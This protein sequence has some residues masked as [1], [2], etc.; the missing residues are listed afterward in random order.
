MRRI[1]KLF[2]IF[3][4]S[5][6]LVLSV[7]ACGRNGEDPVNGEN[8][9]NGENDVPDN[10]E[11][12]ALSG[13]YEIDITNLGMPLVIYLKIDDDGDFMLQTSRAF[14]DPRD[15]GTIR[16]VDEADQD[17]TYLM[18]YDETDN[19]ELRTATFYVVD[20]NLRFQTRM[21]YGGSNIMY[22]AEDPHDP[23]IM[24]YLW[25][26]SFRHE[27]HFGVYGGSHIV[28]AMGQEV[29]YIYSL[30][31]MPGLRYRFES[32]FEMGGEIYDFSE[33]GSFSIED[34][35]FY[36]TPDGASTTE[37]TIEN[38]T[39]KARIQPSAMASRSMRT[40][41]LTTHA[42]YAGL[43][44]SRW[45]EDGVGDTSAIL[46]LDH[47][48]NFTYSAT[49][50]LGEADIALTGTYDVD[51]DADTI[52]FTPEEGDPVTGTYENGYIFAAELPATAEDTHEF[53][54]YAD[55]IQGEFTAEGE[56]EGIPY[57]VTL[58]L[59]GNGTY[60]LVIIEDGAELLNEEGTFAVSVGMIDMIELTLEG[61]TTE[62][63][64]G[65][66]SRA[67]LNIT[68]DVDGIEL[69]FG[70]SK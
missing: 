64:S 13:E 43:Y 68:F 57:E 51:T 19:D 9:E 37:G 70:L 22:E 38:G 67:G 50:H 54:F 52:T 65:P 1:L 34:D 48:G 11:V 12:F 30:E 59:E 29:E 17:D 26:M 61:E 35:V 66:I 24:H 27:E 32:M 16:K 42:E 58:V 45:L 18:I 46:L 28:E 15:T 60:S 4:L 31:L 23:E 39:L 40:L 63:H 69:S 6:F 8:G 2:G 53:T 47:F 44:H 5:F 56:I 62:Q 10:G 14:D 25:A 33:E 55:I 41:T 20:G 21:P 3:T 36:M 49:D 7:A